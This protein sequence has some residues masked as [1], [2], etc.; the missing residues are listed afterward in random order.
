M[1]WRRYLIATRIS[2]GLAA[3][4]SREEDAWARLI[5]DLAEVDY[6]GL[7]VSPGADC[8]EQRKPAC[9]LT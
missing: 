6:S 5:E 9:F 1:A 7:L 3:Y 2:N 8:R 4:P